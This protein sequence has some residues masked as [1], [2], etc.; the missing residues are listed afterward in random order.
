MSIAL[1]C[2]GLLT[3]LVFGLGFGVSLQ[4]RA[5]RYAI[6]T[7]DDPAHPLHRWARAHGNTIEYAPMLAV[8]MLVLHQSTQPAWVTACIIGAT[9]CRFLIAGGLAL[10]PTLAKPNPA[11]FLGAIGTY[12]FGLAL[13]V[14][15]LLQALG[16]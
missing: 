10:A 4:R 15:V 14:A 7:P 5:A 12:L 13:G 2:I 1:I 6:G 8:L 11:R 3:V 16:N 9:A